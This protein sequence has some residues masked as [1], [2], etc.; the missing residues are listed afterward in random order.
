[1]D[2]YGLIGHPV[3]HSSSPAVFDAAFD[4]VGIDAQYVLFPV[5]P[6]NLATAIE[7]AEALGI[8]GL[9]VTIPHKESVLMHAQPT[10][11]AAAIGGA[12]VLDLGEDP[13]V[14]ANTDASAMVTVLDIL[15]L[16]PTEAL[17]LGAGGAARAYVHALVNTGWQV[18]VANRTVKRAA[19]LADRYAA[20]NSHPLDA[21]ADLASTVS[22]IVNA[23]SVGLET[24]VSPLPADAIESTHVVIDAVYEPDPTRLLTD[25]TAAGATTV[26]GRRLLLE[27]AVGAFEIWRD[28]SVPRAVMASALGLEL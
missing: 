20:V 9:N 5:E 3:A 4:T 10:E 24:D 7:G 22:L 28:E 14:A 6:S 8:D 27:Q 1:M 19:E 26:S 21:A 13:I 2:V 11:A 18:H 15:D 23:T 25:A 16:P 12:N 17:V